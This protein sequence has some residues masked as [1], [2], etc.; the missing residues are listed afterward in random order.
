M[1]QIQ[2][3]DTFTNGEQVDATRLNQLLD[4]S[5]LLVGAITEQTTMTPNTVESTDQTIIN[6]G[7]VLKKTTVGSLLNS[8]LPI[9]TSAI[10][11]GDGV[12]IVI[13]P[14]SGREVDIAGNFQVIGNDIVTGNST[15][16]GTFDVTGPA[17]FNT[18]TAIKIPVGTTVQR[19]DT[20]V[21]GQL[22]Y[23]STLDQA[24]VYSGTEWKA[25]GGS[26]FDA[27]GGTVTTVDGF[28]IHTFTASGTFTPALNA[29]G[30][31]EYLVVGAGGAG[32]NAY[33]GAGGGGGEVKAGYLFIAK[34]TSP[35]AVTVGSGASG[36]GTASVF[37][38]VSANGG[39]PASGSFGGASGSGNGGTGGSGSKSGGGGGGAG[40]PSLHSWTGGGCGGEGFGSFISGTLVNY[41]GGGG[42]AGNSS[43]SGSGSGNYGAWGPAGGG[44]GANSTTHASPARVN[45]GGGGGGGTTFNNRNASIGAD[46]IVIV[47]YRVS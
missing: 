31:V 6:D 47:R 39:N 10:T 11:G 38:S 2:K 40:S 19:P 9:G 44:R 28:K 30:K 41:G 7:G 34:N 25:V 32:A 20:P 4:S 16:G 5:A 22:R 43:E 17:S 46:G 3:G 29:E 21:A 12:D 36:T 24:E 33:A 37:S 18:N 26:P 14:A 15:V 27:S 45:S 1:A 35:I 13:T 42:G 23:N 8:N